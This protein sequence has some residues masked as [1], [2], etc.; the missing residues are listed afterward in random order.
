MPNQN[1]SSPCISRRM[2]VGGLA[3]VIAL[4]APSAALSPNP[5]VVVV[6]A[7]IAGLTA[8]RT[9]MNA[10]KSVVVLEAANR[11]GGRAYTEDHTF[12][13]PF[14]HGCSWIN[15]S[16]QNPFTRI[17]RRGGFT[18]LNHTDAGSSFFVDG[19]RA[20][21]AQRRSYDKGWGAVERALGNAGR[22][23]LDVS[24]ASVMPTNVDY[25]GIAQT[26]IGP[27]DWGVDF[28]NL[29]T[30]DYWEAEDSNS[31]YI[32]REGLGSVVAHFG[33]GLPVVLNSPATG[34]DWGGSGVSVQTR[35]GTIRAKTCIVTVSTG[36]LNAGKI[37]FTPALPEWKQ[38]SIA[39]LPMGL[40]AKIAL[41]FDGARLGFVPNHWLDYWVPNIMPAKA[42]YFITWPFNFNYMVGFVGGKFG[43]DLSRAGPAAAIDFALGEVV[44]MVGSDARKH[45][46]KGHLTG[47][48]GNPHTLGAYAAAKPGRFEA[49]E[50]L[51]RPL[52]DKLFFAG[53]AMGGPYV[54]L[55]NGAYTSGESVAKKLLKLR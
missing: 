18:L 8:A 30:K 32:V 39:D 15:S 25:T 42:C 5:D 17:A 48:A 28:A 33:R 29:S 34:I 9:L 47:W 20:T 43:W 24:A 6:G 14:D 26:W 38:Q 11:I 3:S 16:D 54:A 27:M 49:R 52:A 19:T 22:Q 23:G 36:V 35:Q 51:A 40:L 1:L 13:Q 41:Q 7:G 45:F 10:G 31:S 50:H 53:E 55:C 2:V 44:K 4:P 12:G 37:R 21:S 46:V